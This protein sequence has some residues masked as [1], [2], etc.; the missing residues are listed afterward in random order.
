VACLAT[1]IFRNCLANCSFEGWGYSLFC[2]EYVLLHFLQL[3]LKYYLL[4]QEKFLGDIIVIYVDLRLMCVIVRPV[5][6][7]LQLVDKFR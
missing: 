7:N 5:T 6:N 4:F 3:N 2:I 1:Q